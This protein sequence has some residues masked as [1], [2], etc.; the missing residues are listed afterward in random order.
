MCARLKKN[1]II[2]GI[3]AKE[4]SMIGQGFQAYVDQLFWCL[5]VLSKKQVGKPEFSARIRKL[6]ANVENFPLT[7]P[8]SNRAFW[9]AAE[10]FI[11]P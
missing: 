4:I 1:D 11:M 7:Q 10:A 5:P 2:P 3:Y 6:S 8:G 9:I